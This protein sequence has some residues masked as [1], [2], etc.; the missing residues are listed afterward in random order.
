VNPEALK[1][2]VLT[3]CLPLSCIGLGSVAIIF[4]GQFI[5]H[6]G[7]RGDIDKLIKPPEVGET[8]P[9]PKIPTAAVGKNGLKTI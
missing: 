4:I 2:I 6:S 9:E 7:A 3:I 8:I 5:T 1:E